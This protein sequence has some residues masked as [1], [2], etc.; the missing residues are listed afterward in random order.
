MRKKKIDRIW[1]L[2]SRPKISRDFENG[3][4]S[5]A[6]CGGLKERIEPGQISEIFKLASGAVFRMIYISLAISIAA[7]R[8][9]KTRDGDLKSFRIYRQAVSIYGDLCAPP[10]RRTDSPR[11][12]NEMERLDWI[13]GR[14][15]QE[16]FEISNYFSFVDCL[17]VGS[18]EGVDT[19]RRSNF[20]QNL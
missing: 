19:V 13:R 3:S 11:E 6:L 7:R 16:S 10:S 17:R 15:D 12:I 8:N 20:F 1:G 4:L 2:R 9:A 14:R 18:L 5:L